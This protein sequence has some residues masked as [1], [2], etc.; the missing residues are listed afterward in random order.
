MTE[1]EL[2]YYG[3]LAIILI[4]GLAIQILPKM[5]PK[6]STTTMAVNVTKTDYGCKFYWLGGTDYD[7]FV[8]ILVVDGENVGHPPP[9]SEI[10]NGTD[11]NATVKMYMRDVRTLQQI[12]PVVRR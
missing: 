11:C 7:S 1:R 2:M 4:V 3:I 8:T 6:Y 9:G 5:I 10:Y 12:H